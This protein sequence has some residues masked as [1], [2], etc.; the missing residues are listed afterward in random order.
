[1]RKVY[2]RDGGSCFR[3][4]IAS[5]IDHDLE[6][7][8]NFYKGIDPG[9]PVPA[10]VSKWVRDW[11]RSRGLALVGFP[12][13]VDKAD[14]LIRSVC[15]AHPGQAFILAGQSNKGIDHAII[16]R[17]GAVWHDPSGMGWSLAAPQANGCFT[18]YMIALATA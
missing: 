18:V 9:D 3:A 8:P 17:D 14:E 2:D 1:M 5:L 7:V 12:F 6:D 13:K 15:R 10:E 11:M 16:I 4:C